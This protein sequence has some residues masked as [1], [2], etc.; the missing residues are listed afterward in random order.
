MPRARPAQQVRRIIIGAMPTRRFALALVLILGCLGPGPVAGGQDRPDVDPRIERLVNE[1]S[2]ERLRT[3]L[4]RLVSF[5]T[6]NTLSDTSSSVRGIGAA[7]QWIVDEL[8]RSSPRLIVSF[9]TFLLPAQG[10]LTRTTDLR[11]VL[12]VLPGR[13]P[14]RVYVSAHYDSLNTGQQGNP[15]HR[16]ASTDPPEADPQLGPQFNH[17]AD[18][19]GAD[20]NGS[21]TALT[22]EL[23]RIFAESGIE[24]DATLVF[25]LWAGEEQGIF[26][27]TAHA[28]KLEEAKVVVDAVLNNDIVGNVRGGNGVVN[29]TSV[30]VYSDGPE[31]SASRSLARYIARTAAV[32]VPAQRVRTLARE[33]RFNRGD[34]TSFTRSGF[35]AVVFRE[36]AE[37]LGR[38][39]S[40]ADTLDGVDVAYL[41][42]NVRV[43]AAAAAALALAPPGPVLNGARGQ[44]LLSREPSGYDASLRWQA[45]PGAVGYRVYWREAWNLDWQ[46]Q[47]SV[48][49]VT[50]FVLPGVSIDDHV[51]G[52]AAIGAGGGESL[53]SSYRP[54][55]LTLP[56]LKAMD[57]R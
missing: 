29:A 49:N 48:G 15:P 20:D 10:R 17:E 55:A 16:R 26:G 35:P 36:A 12:A 22:M 39:H 44:R 8:R 57:S 52:V 33:D 38:Q 21:G 19:P 6:R 30:R 4:T 9:D 50:H 42:R 28:R 34:H 3:L 51:F 1:I 2:E 11:N 18:A 14:R 53:V 56:P 25:A 24:F 37:D 31:D 13:T 5:G 7:R 32:Y 43:N 27:S 45:V 47:Q 46:H 54:A 40:Q 23:A 41:S